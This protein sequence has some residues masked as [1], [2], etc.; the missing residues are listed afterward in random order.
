M[1]KGYMAR[2]KDE[3]NRKGKEKDKNVKFQKFAK[4]EQRGRERE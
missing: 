2:K 3:D 1:R 4:E